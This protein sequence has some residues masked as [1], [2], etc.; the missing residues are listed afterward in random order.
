MIKQ[1]KQILKYLLPRVWNLLDV[2]KLMAKAS[3]EFTLPWRPPVVKIWHIY[4]RGCWWK[5]A[6]S[7]SKPPRHNP[8]VRESISESLWSVIN[9]E[10]VTIA[11]IIF[12][13][14]TSVQLKKKEKAYNAH[15]SS[16]IYEWRLMLLMLLDAIKF[17]HILITWRPLTT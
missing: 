12:R 4:R 2:L 1:N 6:L 3:I 13:L 16:H 8:F 10:G 14:C 5:I 7:V 9:P 15:S 17:S 11:A